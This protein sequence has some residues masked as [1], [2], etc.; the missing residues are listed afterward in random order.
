MN[1][2][3][4]FGHKKSKAD[5]SKHIFIT[6]NGVEIDDLIK[7]IE[8]IE[9]AAEFANLKLKRRQNDSFGS[10]SAGGESCN[11]TLA[12]NLICL[13]LKIVGLEV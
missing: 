9:K 13:M 1:V 3:L 10:D 12:G 7:T 6:R 8:F 2:G 11:G 4:M 5:T